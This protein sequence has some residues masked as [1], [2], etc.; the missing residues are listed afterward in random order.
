[1][2]TPKLFKNENWDEIRSFVTQ[3]GFAVLVAT[4]PEGLPQAVH[5]PLELRPT[6][7]GHWVLQGHIARANPL[8][9]VIFAQQNLLAI[10]HGPHAYIS[11]SWYDHV[12]VPTWNYIAVHIYGHVRELAGTEAVEAVEH[13]V[14]HYEAQRPNRF[15][16]GQLGEK[17]FQNDMRGIV[18][19]EMAVE[20]VQ[21]TYKLSQNRNEVSHQQVVSQLAA[22]S[23][24]AERAVAEAMQKPK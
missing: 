18:V 11:S 20:D 7:A 6:A 10:F 23:D 15:E 4:T 3:N 19:F 21:A 16:I 9:E 5:I 12:N 1:M 2:Y 17:T 22:S 8:K 24:S 13:L 14:G